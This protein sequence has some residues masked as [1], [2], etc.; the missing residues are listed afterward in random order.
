MDNYIINEVHISQIKK[1]HTILHTDNKIRTV[2]KNNIKSGF[3]GIT[4]FGESYILRTVLVK[5]ITF[6]HK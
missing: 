1:S 5:K 3:M 2:C 4:L 6:K